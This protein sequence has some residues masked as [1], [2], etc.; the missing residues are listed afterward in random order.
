MA[1]LQAARM[2]GP[3][4]LQFLTAGIPK[5]QLAVRVGMDVLGGGMAALYTPGD[6]GDKLIAGVTDAGFSA[7]V[8]RPSRDTSAPCRACPTAITIQG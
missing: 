8:P 4:L 5:D 7:A 2:A 1:F 6:L 3:K